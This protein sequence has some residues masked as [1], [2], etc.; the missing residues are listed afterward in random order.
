M[1]DGLTKRSGHTRGDIEHAH[2][3]ALGRSEKLPRGGDMGAAP[4]RISK[5]FPD[6][7]GIPGEV[8]SMGKNTKR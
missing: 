1:S 8:N 7:K 2:T 6:G 5:S 4:R 3:V